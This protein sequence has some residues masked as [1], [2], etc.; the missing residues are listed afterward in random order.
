MLVVPKLGI[1]ALA[2][3]RPVAVSIAH[4]RSPASR[5]A[6]P[7]ASRIPSRRSSVEMRKPS[8]RRQRSRPAADVDGD[9]LAGGGGEREAAVD[10]EQLGA[11]ERR[12]A[13]AGQGALLA[14]VDEA[15]VG[16]RG[17]QAVAVDDRAGQLAVRGVDVVGRR[18]RR[19]PR[20]EPD[21]PPRPPDPHVAGPREHAEGDVVAERDRG[22]STRLVAASIRYSGPLG[23]R[24]KR[25]PQR[26][27]Q[28]EVARRRRS[29]SGGRA[30]GGAH[31]AA[32]PVEPQQLLA[33]RSR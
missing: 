8:G 23:V 24:K 22:P 5:K 4:S 25:P 27:A 29:R 18:D 32:A 6:A 2:S 15:A 30:P 7:W 20:L 11:H 21:H 3:T 12:A 19:R 13:R 26:S 33:A 14:E 1:V 31:T 10:G 9:E 28:T 16:R 17:Q